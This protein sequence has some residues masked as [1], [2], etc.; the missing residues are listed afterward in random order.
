MMMNVFTVYDAAVKAFM[1]PFFVRS[2]GEALRTFTA[3][4]NEENSN[5][6]KYPADY[7]LFALGEYDDQSGVFSTSVP[8]RVIS[9]LECVEP[10]KAPEVISPFVN[11][12]QGRVVL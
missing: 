9:A 4:C 2:T 8:V 5:F 11:G 1:Q 3:A 6:R 12:S 7:T 10:G